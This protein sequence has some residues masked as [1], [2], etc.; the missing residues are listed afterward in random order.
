MSDLVPA[1]DI[2]RI[3]G[4]RR[5]PTEHYARAVSAEE[6]I[7]ILH[8][9]ECLDSGVD[10]RDCLFSLSLDG[11]IDLAEWAQDAPLRVVVDEN[12]FFRPSGAVEEGK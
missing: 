11:G 6:T 3:V 1:G 7:Y 9:R 8:S 10:L 2:E 12:G 4:V 5:H